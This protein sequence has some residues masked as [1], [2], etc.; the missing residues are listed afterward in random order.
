MTRR[1][2][3]IRGTESETDGFTGLDGEV[4]VVTDDYTLRVHDGV[5]PGGHA[6]FGLRGIGLKTLH[7]LTQDEYDAIAEPDLE[8]LYIIVPARIAMLP[9][10]IVMTASGITIY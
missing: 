7:V 3:L 6:V 4:S 2:Q 1:V 9:A 10:E 8:T 5:T